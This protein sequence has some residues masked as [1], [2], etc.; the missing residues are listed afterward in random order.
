MFAGCQQLALQNVHLVLHHPVQ[1][2]HP[3]QITLQ[4]KPGGS[5]EFFASL[6]RLLQL[7]VH[8]V[9]VG[10]LLLQLLRLRHLVEARVQL[11]LE[12]QILLGDGFQVVDLG[13][14]Q[15]EGVRKNDIDI[16]VQRTEVSV[17]ME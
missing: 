8:T 5:L 7:L 2:L 13:L 4:S 3:I 16:L 17:L 12:Q 6:A 14:R 9:N 1:L 11:L 15:S 10:H